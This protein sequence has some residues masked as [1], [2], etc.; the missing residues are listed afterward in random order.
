MMIVALLMRAWMLQMASLG[1]LPKALADDLLLVTTGTNALRRFAQAFQA[2]IHHLH[3]MGGRIASAKSIL[4][5]NNSKVR[6][7]L[8]RKL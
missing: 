8:A 5:S 3:D 2:T 6:T 1:A 7:W 4:F